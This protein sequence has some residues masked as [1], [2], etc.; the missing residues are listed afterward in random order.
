MSELTAFPSLG[1]DIRALRKARGMTLG[2]LAGKLDCSTGWLSQVERDKSTVRHRDVKRIADALDVPLSLLFGETP[3][4]PGEDG[5]IVRAG[6]RR[7][8]GSDMGLSEELLSPDLTDAFE[9]VHATFAPHARLRAPVQRATQELGYVVSGQL[10]IEIGGRPFTVTAG[11]SF[12]I[13]GE[14]Y[15]WANP[16]AE[17]CLVIWVIAPPVY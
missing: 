15:R 5:F 12:R 7:V 16:S 6:A 8:I 2:D 13:R 17:P 14:V 4:Q 10:E 11:D 3:S 9:V 1:E